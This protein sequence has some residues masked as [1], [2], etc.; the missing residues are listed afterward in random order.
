[1]NVPSP[2][3]VVV[4]GPPGSGKTQLAHALATAI[5]CPAVIRDAIKEGMVHATGGA[6][7]ASVGDELTG[8]T[9]P[10]FFEVIRLLLAS[11]V[12]VVAEAAFQDPNWRNGLSP[13]L[14][15]AELRIIHCTVDEAVAKERVIR[16]MSEPTR[17][18]HADAQWMPVVERGFERISLPAPSLVVDTTNGYVPDLA[19]IVSFVG[20]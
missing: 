16:R 12:T 2:T 17:A 5:G 15:L 19:A 7:K 3:L 6:F 8:R 10:V 11:G 4:T 20:R 14:P 13:L 9:F 18:A 1:M